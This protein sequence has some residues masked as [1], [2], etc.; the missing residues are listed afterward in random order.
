MDKIENLE[1]VQSIFRKKI[2]ELGFF[3]KYKS[4]KKLG[5]GAT[6]DVYLVQRISDKKLFA[7]KIISIKNSN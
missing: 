1:T 5:R 2:C 7:A 3:K 6:A 4:L